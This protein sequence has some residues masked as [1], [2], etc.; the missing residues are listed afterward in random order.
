M[1]LKESQGEQLKILRLN[2]CIDLEFQRI[3]VF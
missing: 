3:S 2:I 1:L